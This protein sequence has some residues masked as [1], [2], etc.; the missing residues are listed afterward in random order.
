MNDLYER[1]HG[2]L[3]A[4][5]LTRRMRPTLGEIA[6]NILPYAS[7]ETVLKYVVLCVEEIKPYNLRGDLW[8]AATA[9]MMLL[10]GRPLSPTALDKIVK[11]DITLLGDDWECDVAEGCNP[12]SLAIKCSIEC[13]SAIERY[14]RGY[15]QEAIG[16]AIV[17]VN[18]AYFAALPCNRMNIMHRLGAGLRTVAMEADGQQ[19]EAHAARNGFDPNDKLVLP[20]HF[21]YVKAQ[22]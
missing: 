17:A 14:Q 19:I 7:R 18:C 10:Q 9:V 5:E 16:N 13:V 12:R 1:Y 6:A 8:K 2:P 15:A 20:T 3:S 21:D 22:A 11:E 4:Y